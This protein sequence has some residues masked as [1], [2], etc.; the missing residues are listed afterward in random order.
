MLKK[1]LQNG[2]GIQVKSKTTLSHKDKQNLQ[3][4]R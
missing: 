4:R 2:I 1:R 3:Q